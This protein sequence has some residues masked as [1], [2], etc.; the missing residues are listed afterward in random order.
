MVSPAPPNSAGGT[1]GAAGGGGLQ[2]VGQAGGQQAAKPKFKPS[3]PVCP[4]CIKSV[5]KMEEVLCEKVSFHKWCFRCTIPECNKRLT[6]GK[7]ASYKGGFYCKPCF[8]KCFK[9]HGNYDKGF[10][11]EQHKMQW[12]VGEAGERARSG[13]GQPSDTAPDP[14]ATVAFRP[15]SQSWADSHHTPESIALTSS[16]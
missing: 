10:G 5:Y 9:Q 6:A 7:Y 13:E 3:G 2:A 15:G 8:M 12:S 4:V 1:S 11:H 16:G 14:A